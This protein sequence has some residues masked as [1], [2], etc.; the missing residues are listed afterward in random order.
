MLQFRSVFSV[1]DFIEMLVLSRRKQ[2]LITLKIK[3]YMKSR[4]FFL[5][6]N[7]MWNLLSELLVFQHLFILK[8]NSNSKK[9]HVNGLNFLVKKN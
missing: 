1:N 3:K 9:I 2:K 7:I 5:I 6:L 4:C 8:Q